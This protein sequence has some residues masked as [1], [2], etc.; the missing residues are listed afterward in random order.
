ML[1]LLEKNC[2]TGRTTSHLTKLSDMF[3]EKYIFHEVQ[4]SMLCGQHAL[5]NLLQES[6][7]TPVDLAEI[8]QDLDAQEM[9]FMTEGGSIT[10]DT[11][12]FL[13]EK[14]GNV[15]ESG[16]FSIQV[17]RA[18]IQRSHGI[19]LISWTAD[20]GQEAK[21]MTAEQG[22]IVN[23][24]SHWFTI[25]KISTRWWNLNSSLEYP[26]VITE[27]YL[28][29]FLSQLI[30]DGYTVFQAKGSI[31]AGGSKPFG[32]SST[33]STKW[34]S[35][36]ELL[37]KSGSAAAE[38]NTFPGA[39]R[40]LAGTKAADVTD[41][42]DENALY[43]QAIRASLEESG[44]AQNYGFEDDDPELAMALALS[45]SSAE[46]LPGTKAANSTASSGPDSAK[47]QMRQKRL[48]A[49]SKRGL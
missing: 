22:F 21:E 7:F 18:A 35:E 14:S 2:L 20:T 31:P 48:D 43:E 17:L 24:S 27:F 41:G 40:R 11:M 36:K 45:R 39:G 34:Y 3:S 25:R 10:S 44:G 23:R 9:K 12:K 29:A 42:M 49:L 6:C 32:S 47:E 4:D 33:A 8:A 37:T 15:D 16:N 5:N 38:S 1:Q 46:E 13:S 30:G 19:E 28:T 26:E